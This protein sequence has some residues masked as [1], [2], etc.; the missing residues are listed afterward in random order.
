M[1]YEVKEMPPPDHRNGSREVPDRS[2][3]TDQGRLNQSAP[4]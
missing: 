4:R 2:R 3:V 1:N